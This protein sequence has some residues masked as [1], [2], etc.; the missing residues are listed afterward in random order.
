[1][2]QKD[3][4]RSPK[5]AA[6][7]ISNAYIIMFAMVITYRLNTRELGNNL[8]TS[9]KDAYPEQDIEILVARQQD[10]T[11]YLCRSPVNYER[12][13]QAIHNVEHGKNL[14]AFENIEQAA[15]YAEKLAAM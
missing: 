8:I 5:I 2:L 12:L 10:E 13:K 3:K 11:E 4:K 14:L 9:L 6:L 15:Q 1:M 7:Y